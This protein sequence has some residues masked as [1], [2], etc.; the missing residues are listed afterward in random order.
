[1]IIWKTHFPV[2]HVFT[3]KWSCNICRKKSNLFTTQGCNFKIIEVGKSPGSKE[4]THFAYGERGE[5][6]Y[7]VPVLS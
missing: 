3:A 2:S 5:L 1:M 6:G 4:E 7:N